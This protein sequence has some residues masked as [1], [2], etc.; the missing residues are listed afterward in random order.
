MGAKFKTPRL[1]RAQGMGLLEPHLPAASLRAKP[2]ACPLAPTPAEGLRTRWASARTALTH[3]FL[4]SSKVAFPERL[5]PGHLIKTTLLSHSA[6]P[7]SILIAPCTPDVL[8]LFIGVCS[9]NGR[10][11]PGSVFSS[12]WQP[13][14]SPE[15]CLAILRTRLCLQG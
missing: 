4:L 11:S 7:G 3:A 13:P 15:R 10:E 9:L 8:Y 5:F 6:P 2:S 1:A 14:Q 12:C